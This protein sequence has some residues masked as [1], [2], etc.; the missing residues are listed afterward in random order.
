MYGLYSAEVAL[1]DLGLYKIIMHVDRYFFPLHVRCPCLGLC[2]CSWKVS[3]S[4]NYKF[5]KM[6]CFQD[7][8]NA[9]KQLTWGRGLHDDFFSLSE[10]VK[11]L[12]LGGGRIE[13]LMTLSVCYTLGFVKS[14]NHHGGRNVLLSDCTSFLQ[15]HRGVPISHP[16]F[17]L[18]LFHRIFIWLLH[19]PIVH[20]LFRFWSQSIWMSKGAFYQMGERGY[21]FT[22]HCS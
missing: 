6:D 17:L 11:P 18:H 10:S 19:S 20:L 16:L 12:M 2:K 8:F 14:H 4:F 5:L 3:I 13:Y 21:Q 1:T 22:D 9:L 15:L 7:N